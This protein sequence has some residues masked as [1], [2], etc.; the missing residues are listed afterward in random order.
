MNMIIKDDDADHDSQAEHHRVFV[1][2]FR[3]VLPDNPVTQ[4]QYLITFA[5]R[6]SLAV[7]QVNL[8][9]SLKPA[10]ALTD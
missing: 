7:V 9:N 5:R 10:T 1:C 4:Q 6:H 2:E 8:A 3:P